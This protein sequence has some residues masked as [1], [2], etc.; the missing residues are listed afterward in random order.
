MMI[1]WLCRSSGQHW[2]ADRSWSEDGGVPPGSFPLQ[3]VD[4][5]G[6]DEVLPGYPYHRFHAQCSLHLFQT[7]GQGG[8][9]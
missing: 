6:G 2:S 9:Q 4:Y 8:G 3:D 1:N 5:L 7:E